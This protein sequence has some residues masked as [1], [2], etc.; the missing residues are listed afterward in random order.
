MQRSKTQKYEK[1]SVQEPERYKKP[2]M[3][4]QK[5]NSHRYEIPETAI[6]E[7]SETFESVSEES[8]V[9]SLQFSKQQS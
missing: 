7:E 6:I 2:Y 3:T 8:A 4:P 1:L 9:S 5:K